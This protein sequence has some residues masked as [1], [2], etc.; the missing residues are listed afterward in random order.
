[1]SYSARET[2]GETR[3]DKNEAKEIL[4]MLWNATETSRDNLGWKY[5]INCPPSH[6]DFGLHSTWSTFKFS[7]GGNQS[8]NLQELSKVFGGLVKSRRRQ[9]LVTAVDW[10]HPS[11]CPQFYITSQSALD[12]PCYI[13]S[14]WCKK[15]DVDT[16]VVSSQVRLQKLF[17]GYLAVDYIAMNPWWLYSQ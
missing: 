2:E 11:A 8:L 13:I 10:S 3:Q 14:F 9:L 15:S 7:W 16:F 5:A 12:F 4:D 1:M 17:W 6:S